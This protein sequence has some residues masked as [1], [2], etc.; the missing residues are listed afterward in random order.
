[1]LLAFFFLIDSLF[2]ITYFK[3]WVLAAGPA[4]HPNYIVYQTNVGKSE[5][6]GKW[7]AMVVQT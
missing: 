1:M 5:F 3:W 2:I 4:K 7:S 6:Q